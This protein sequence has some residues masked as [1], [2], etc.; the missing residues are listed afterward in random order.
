[1]CDGSQQKE[2]HADMTAAPLLPVPLPPTSCARHS[3]CS[4]STIFSSFCS[5]YPHGPG[6]SLL[7]ELDFCPQSLLMFRGWRFPARLNPPLCPVSGQL[8]SVQLDKALNSAVP[9]A[10]QSCPL[11]PICIFLSSLQ[12]LRNIQGT[13]KPTESQSRIARGSE[14]AEKG[15]LTLSCHQH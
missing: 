14:S 12:G 3:Y 8:Y 6:H 13:Q 10:P 2:G 9:S 15:P 1:M 11:F 5:C 7:A 4:L